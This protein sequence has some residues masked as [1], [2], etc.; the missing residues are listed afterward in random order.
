MVGVL[1][2]VSDLHQPVPKV[3]GE[4]QAAGGGGVQGAALTLAD[5]EKSAVSIDDLIVEPLARAEA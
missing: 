4:T 2:V 5:I 1:A 3:G